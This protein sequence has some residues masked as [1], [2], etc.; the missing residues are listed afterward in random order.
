[1]GNNDNKSV[2]PDKKRSISLPRSIKMINKSYI[3][4]N[5]TNTEDI[6]SQCAN[7]KYKEEK[8]C[9]DPILMNSIQCH[10]PEDLPASGLSTA[11]LARHLCKVGHGRLPCFRS[12]DPSTD[13][14][15][16]C[17]LFEYANL[18]RKYN[19]NLLR[20][21]TLDIGAEAYGRKF[22]ALHQ[23]NNQTIDRKAIELVNSAFNGELW[24]IKH[25]L[26]SLEKIFKDSSLKYVNASLNVWCT[27]PKLD[28]RDWP[29]IFKGMN[30][31]ISEKPK[32]DPRY[33]EAYI[34]LL[35]L[36][37]FAAL[38]QNHK[39]TTI[40][41][42][43]NNAHKMF[44]PFI[45]TSTLHNA[46]GSFAHNSKDIQPG[47]RLMDIFGGLHHGLKIA[48]IQKFECEQDNIISSDTTFSNLTPGLD[49][50]NLISP[51]TCGK[52]EEFNNVTIRVDVRF[53]VSLTIKSR[54]IRMLDVRSEVW[55]FKPNENNIYISRLVYKAISELSSIITIVEALEDTK[56]NPISPISPIRASF[57][58]KEKVI[59][60]KEKIN[61]EKEKVIDRF[62]FKKSYS[63]KV[64]CDLLNRK[65]K[66]VIAEIRSPWIVSHESIRE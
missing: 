50:L 5:V 59:D 61:D 25:E 17:D 32:N 62:N 64:Y 37:I 49:K 39:K 38:L 9:Q 40:C 54:G 16:I 41:N 4:G 13:F 45:T 43:L 47:L 14:D 60:E 12:Q 28:H 55:E 44:L 24:Q 23:N 65:Y 2:I 29:A 10:K 52:H 56:N 26:E 46:E 3:F 57:F 30:M 6:I 42:T 22:V 33:F 27:K 66:D 21:E 34:T 53:P 48:T 58:E 31:F 35:S 36:Y 63:R 15:A 1:M 11:R 20:H 51:T 7:E 18:L 8:Y 19:A